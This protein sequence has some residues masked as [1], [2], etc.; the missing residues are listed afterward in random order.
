MTA[1]TQTT[2]TNTNQK[3]GELTG[4]AL[5]LEA[6]AS[7][8]S[9][10]AATRGGGTKGLQQFFTPPALAEFIKS[11]LDPFGG[12]HVLDLTAGDGSLL[13]PFDSQRRVGIEIDHDQIKAAKAGGTGYAA[14]HGDVQRILPLLRLTGQQFG[15]VVLNPPFGLTWDVAGQRMN[16]TKA[17][18]VMALSV[19]AP[20]GQG[21]IIGGAKRLQDEI[22]SDETLRTAVFAEVSIPAGTFEGVELEVSVLFFAD[23][24][25]RYTPRKAQS[26]PCVDGGN[27]AAARS[28]VTDSRRSLFVTLPHRDGMDHDDLVQDLRHVQQEHARRRDQREGTASADI[29]LTAKNRISVHLSAITTN[30][31][32]SAAGSETVAGLQRLD[33]LTVNYFA[34]NPREWKDVAALAAGAVLT[35]D[36]GLAA[37]VESVIEKA[38]ALSCP[39]Y[40]IKPQQRLGYLADTE[41]IECTVSDPAKGFTAG[42][43]YPV[44]TKSRIATSERTETKEVPAE[45]GGMSVKEL[46]WTRKAKV[47]DITLTPG[48]HFR[49][50]TLSEKKDDIEYLLAHFALPDPGDLATKFPAQMEKCRAVLRRIEA[51]VLAPRGFSL[52]EYQREDVC[53]LMMKQ[54]GILSWEQGLGKTMGAMMFT[55]AQQ[56]SRQTDGN[57]LFIVPQ[58]LIPQWQAEAMKFFGRELVWI[59][60]RPQARAA[61]QAIRA[62]RQ[63]AK[64]DPFYEAGSGWYITHYEALSIGGTQGKVTL[65]VDTAA[66]RERQTVRTN[67]GKVILPETLVRHVVK[68]CV[69]PAGNRLGRWEEAKIVRRRVPQTTAQLCPQ[70]WQ[71][72]KRATDTDSGQYDGVTCKACGYAHKALHLKPMAHELTTAF[73]QGTVVVDEGTK[74]KGDSLQSLAVRGLRARRKLILTGTPVKNAIPDLFHLEGWSCGYNSPRFPFT[75]DGGLDK[76][77]KDFCVIETLGGAKGRERVLNEITNLSMS[78]KRTTGNYV[79][80]RKEDSGEPLVPRK[81]VPVTVPM[82]TLQRRQYAHWLNG[83]TSFYCERNPSADPAMVEMSAAIL[84]QLHKLEYASTLPT[85]DPDAD[86]WRVPVSDWTPKTLK[87]C[88][89]AAFHAAR[90]ERVLVGS[91]VMKVGKFVA[92][93]LNERGIPAGHILEED[94]RGNTKTMKPSDRAGAVK[95]FQ[96]GDTR[97]LCAGVQSIN[98]GHNMDQASVVI[99]DGLPWDYATLDQFIARVHRL[100]SKRPVTVYVVMTESSLD[101]RKW[102]TLEDKGK[103]ANLALDGDLFEK[104][105]DPI[106]VKAILKE[107]IERGLPAADT[108]QEADCQRLWE[109]QQFTLQPIGAAYAETALPEEA[110]APNIKAQPADSLFTFE[111]ILPTSKK[112]RNAPALA[113][114]YAPVIK[115]GALFAL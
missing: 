22:L 29:C 100:S 46:A 6:L 14:L 35:L 88:E 77:R 92:D 114:M 16:R 12:W 23:P 73:K 84:G 11:V 63:E 61:A 110:P 8:K 5:T 112:A 39:V 70:C 105:Q 90:G 25:H 51:D 113:S 65:P 28:Q 103:V 36:T 41:Q 101:E 68:E 80:R 43:F 79:R 15:R 1:T 85:A 19:L 55:T 89:I 48:N 33:G 72:D 95:A 64:A 27:L 32:M 54:G 34:Q 53:R 42:E 81:F 69:V 13:A 2:Q 108:V 91:D 78:W 24:A 86:Y 106:N 10:L 74:I 4:G 66:G 20:G 96:E 102:S 109:S 45:N 93:A 83:F 107:M 37:Q 3:R 98:L 75:Y 21:A 104:E 97:V 9:V 59:K 94:S 47:L 60:T 115:Q 56:Y 49:P 71:R 62:E 76:F 18:F 7:S 31:I 50:V 67:Q 99:L 52:K 87:V 58:D 17:A 44:A 40:P 30:A 111:T 26:A 57:T 82:G 38:A